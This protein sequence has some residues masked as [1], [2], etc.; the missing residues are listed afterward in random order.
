MKNIQDLKEKRTVFII[1]TLT[2][3]TPLAIDKEGLINPDG[4]PARPLEDKDVLETLR[5]LPVKELM[6]DQGEKPAMLTYKFIEV[7]P[8]QESGKA[9]FKK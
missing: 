5:E 3:F 7:I 6:G 4:T 1:G 2:F 8:L 9:M